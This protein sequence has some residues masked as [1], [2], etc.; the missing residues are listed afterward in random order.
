MA[1]K[2]VVVTDAPSEAE[3]TLLS[4]SSGKLLWEILEGEGI[5]RK[6]CYVT[7]LV[8]NWISDTEI[9]ANCYS[10]EWLALLRE[11]LLAIKPN[12]VLA[13]G[14]HVL[15][16]LCNYDPNYNWLNAAKLPLMNWRG[17]LM[18]ST[19]VPGL[20][21]LPSIH[22]TTVLRQW[23]WR[24]LLQVDTSKIKY[25][26]TFPEIRRS[27]RRFLLFPTFNESID[28]LE[29]LDQPYAIDIEGNNSEIACVGFARN[30]S[31]AMCIP[32][33]TQD[34]KPCWNEHQELLIWKA[35]AKQLARPV[36]IVAQN[37]IYDLFWLSLYGCK[38][39]LKEIYD[40]MLMINLRYP[41][42]DKGLDMIGSIY[43]D[44]A[45]WKEDGK[46]W[47]GLKKISDADFFTYNLKDC[48]GTYEGYQGL[49]LDL[50]EYK[51]PNTGSLLTFYR[52]ITMKLVDCVMKSMLRGVRVDIP[53][54]SKVYAQYQQMIVDKIAAFR[55][56]VKKP[57][58]NPNSTKQLAKYL[59]EEKGYP[60]QFKRKT[61]RLT[62]DDAAL[63]KLGSIYVLPELDILDEIREYTKVA[64]TYLN[65]IKLDTDM[66]MRFSLNIGGTDSG[67]M[68]SSA[69]PLR[70]GGNI[71]NVAKGLCRS[72][73]IP[74]TQMVWLFADQ[75]Q[76][77]VRIV[78]HAAPEPKLIELYRQ[79]KD[80]H[81]FNAS[82]AFDVDYA[83]VTKPMRFVAKQLVHA[84]DY[85][86]QAKTFAQT[87]NKQAREAGISLHF[88]TELANE[89][90]EK[91]HSYFTEIRGSY[92]K[93]IQKSLLVEPVLYNLLGRPHIFLGRYGPDM[94]RK[95][96]NFIPQSTVADVE[97]I[98]WVT[99]NERYP[100]YAVMMQIHDELVVQCRMDEV[101]KVKAALTEC[102][103]IELEA[104][105]IKFKIPIE[106]AI[107]T[108]RWSE[109][110]DA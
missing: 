9:E 93:N 68:S 29:S 42:M 78:A 84:A 107:T 103:D 13:L 22:P 92:H 88:T 48:M 39:Y 87:I 63:K 65:P 5:Q 72:I 45:F 33:V 58:M 57:G 14:P 6:D 24:G 30:A 69:C 80:V 82:I 79:K 108:T 101:D 94:F 18:E 4:G 76:A 25:E 31:E 100:Q 28:Y 85:D 40:T 37:A 46:I 89:K 54:Q 10:Q 60:K 96:Y 12:I 73:Y 26:S 7:S 74:D 17:S 61:H 71:Q 91:F 36:P 27:E 104:N 53:L 67:R 66:R 59:Y 23:N 8:K 34:L 98:G 11:E 105:G 15:N 35:I 86:V 62:V 38:P 50:D 20:K 44:M 75:S 19:L 32:I 43:S 102:F 95:A 99:F 81:K 55:E 1:S 77:E 52:K 109:K 41:E 2:I 16:A 47:K 64:S 21:V 70:T 110:Q 97:N 90:L 56:I 49:L 83:D 3:T 51:L 106:F